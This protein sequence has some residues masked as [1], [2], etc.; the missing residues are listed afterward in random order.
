MSLQSGMPPL[1]AFGAGAERDS[2]Q[3][4]RDDV[5]DPD[6]SRNGEQAGAEPAVAR[7]PEVDEQRI[8]ED[9]L[10]AFIARERDAR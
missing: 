10:D 9:A 1:P 4:A 6:T 7:D 3:E 8:N 2:A 5:A